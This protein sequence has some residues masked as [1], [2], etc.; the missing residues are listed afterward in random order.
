MRRLL[1]IV[2]ALAIA[3]VLLPWWRDRTAD[4][5]GP[6]PPTPP[7]AAALPTAPAVTPATDTARSAGEP[8]ADAGADPAAPQREAVAAGGPA[9]RV[10]VVEAGTGRAVASATVTAWDVATLSRRLHGEGVAIESPRGRALKRA[11]AV[12]AVTGADGSATV[13]I[14]APRVNVEAR[15]GAA[16]G[17]VPMVLHEGPDAPGEVVVE[18]DRDLVLWAAVTDARGEPIADVPVVLRAAAP[19][20]PVSRPSERVTATEAP[21]GL[22][23]FEHVQ[24]RFV[25]CPQW[26][27][28]LGFPLARAP[29]AV[30]TANAFPGEPVPLP[31][32]ATGSLAIAVVDSAGAPVGPDRAALQVDAFAA[33]NPSEPLL[34][35]GSWARPRL[36]QRGEA[37]L[38]WLGLGLSLRVTAA[39]VDR[40]SELLPVSVTV[41]GPRIAG[42]RAACRITFGTGGLRWPVV[43]GR[44]VRRDGT[45]WPRCTVTALPWYVPGA[46]D[47]MQRQEFV[48]DDDG[49]FRLAVRAPRLDGG[50]CGYRLTAPDP[51][52]A[53]SV[54]GDLDLSRALADVTD[55]GDVL[56][57]HGPPL[58]RGR[59]VG[60]DDVPIVGANVRA[61]APYRGGQPSDQR[62]VSVTGTSRTGT[63]GSFEPFAVV[64]QDLPASGLSVRASAD[65]FVTCAPQPFAIGATG[66][67]LRLERAGAIAGS[68]HLLAGQTA[69]D[70]RL[71][72]RA[73]ARVHVPRIAPD[74]TFRCDGLA[75]GLYRVRAE[76]RVDDRLGRDGP[77]VTID[78]VIVR[79]G[80]TTEDPRLAG[81]TIPA[82][83]D[84]LALRVV[85]ADDAPIPRATVRVLG[86]GRGGEVMSGADGV[87]VLRGRSL[88]IDLEVDAWGHRP[89]QLLGVDRDRTVT[90]QRGLAAVLVCTGVPA[91]GT[92]PRYDLGVRLYG[93]IEP[94]RFGPML[95]PTTTPIDKL[96]FDAHGELSM[97]LPAPGRYA[98]DPHVF[99]AGKDNVGRGGNLGL[100]LGLFVDVVD[101]DAPQHLPVEIPRDRLDEMLARLTK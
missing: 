59:V 54:T 27:L 99:V 79:P 73:D 36:S 67:E 40:D 19:D 18:L 30:V 80:E 86:E 52:R 64:D 10:H 14:D 7:S 92:A 11:I 35:G 42:E 60:I 95:W 3:V 53:G 49:R 65:D 13:A 34:P 24:R 66:V 77:G 21:A 55:L 12:E 8:T 37:T 100:G 70:V 26:L 23:R 38:P 5:P 33:A 32:P 16:W 76:L 47:A 43:T 20:G 1:V 31:L 58:V 15:S 51:D 83:V 6:A 44:L 87:A 85:G 62:T 56:L 84:E 75:A 94:G 81:L 22:A 4:V 61:L 88:P 39:P 50:R 68:L 74:G 82:L 91:H 69:D 78:G 48:V 57:D 101:S 17:I 71:L 9:L 2:A 25:T 45:P 63:D 90:L 89:Q 72:V 28:T 93:P 97:H 41:D 29:S 46:P 96:Y 98:I